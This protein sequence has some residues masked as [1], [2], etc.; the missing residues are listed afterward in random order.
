MGEPVLRIHFEGWRGMPHS[1]SLVAR[2]LLTELSSRPAV[3]APDG[4]VALMMTL[5]TSSW[6]I[7]LVVV[8]RVAKNMRPTALSWPC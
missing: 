1:Y 4:T 2:A 6:L 8:F 7:P 5:T 3:S